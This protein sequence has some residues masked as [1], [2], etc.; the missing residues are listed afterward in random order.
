MYLKLRIEADFPEIVNKSVHLGYL[1]EIT[2]INCSWFFK[3]KRNFTVTNKVS[4]D[5]DISFFCLETGCSKN[6]ALALLSIETHA[7]GVEYIVQRCTL[8]YSI[9]N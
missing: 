6:L 9:F 8:S 1:Y 5:D 4:Q 3:R 2:T 7:P